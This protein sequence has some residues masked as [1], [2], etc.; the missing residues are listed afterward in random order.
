MKNTSLLDCTL[1]D[2]GYIND[3]DF[4]Y[5]VAKS[6]ISSLVQAGVDYIELGFL[7]DCIYDPNKTLFNN[8]AEAKKL[9]PIHTN[10]TAIT[11][12]ALHNQYSLD[13]LEDNDDSIFAIRVTFHDYDIDEGL[14]YMSRL[15]EKG[16]RVFCN[17]IN[18]M[19]YAEEEIITILDKVNKLK[20][21]AFSIVDTFGSMRTRDLLRLLLICDS[22]LDKDIV[23]GCHLHENLSFALSLAETFI[24]NK[25]PSRNCI[26]DASL[27]G[28]GRIP[29]NLCIELIANY[30]N[31]QSGNEL[32]KIDYFLEAIDNH[33]IHIK[34]KSTWGYSP[35]YFL[36]AK[37]NLHRNYAEFYHGKGNITYKTIDK[38]LSKIPDVKKSVFDENFAENML[39]KSFSVDND[40]TSE[41]NGVVRNAKKILLMAPGQSVVSEKDR[42]STFIAENDVTVFC[43]NFLSELY[44][45]TITFFGN[46]K[47]FI[48]YNKTSNFN[49]KRIVITSNISFTSDNTIILDYANAINGVVNG[50]N[51]I[52]MLI[53]LLYRAGV[54]DLWFAGMDGYADN[55]VNYLNKLFENRVTLSPSENKNIVIINELFKVSK[56]ISLHFITKSIYQEQLNKLHKI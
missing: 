38:V 13:K 31:E 24:K 2:G 36:S 28:M 40:D 5:E 54:T 39:I 43:V 20:P 1:R 55:N 48:E 41:F 27:Y 51:S 11:L 53:N 7:R 9:I 52:F 16:Y 50:I 17:P 18:I 6:L 22:R 10:N 56:V 34:D 29:G 30:L 8:I 25:L 14:D 32:Y 15:M 45:N 4:G 49:N 47:R 12:M 33:I 46:E 21:Y 19:G 44:S 23:I 3:W 26:I 37:Y 35:E 42:I